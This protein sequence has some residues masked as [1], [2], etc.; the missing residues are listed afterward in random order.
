MQTRKAVRPMQG[1]DLSFYST[2]AAA[3]RAMYA[4]CKAAVQSIDLEQYIFSNDIMG[5][6]FLRLFTAKA[7]QGVTV[8]M[9]LDGLGSRSVFATQQLRAFEKAGGL[10]HFYNRPH[11]YGV[12][13]P[14]RWLPRNHTKSMTIDARVG[15]VGGVCIADHMND[16]RDLHV[17]VA[18]DLVDDMKRDLDIPSDVANNII[19]N[20]KGNIKNKKQ[21]FKST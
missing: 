7:K 9:V 18:G 13:L 10:V 11:W 1:K 4:D 19:K 5:H 3:W 8:R 15:Y 12:P 20:S 21:S 16:W 6:R 14:F 2:P 17:R